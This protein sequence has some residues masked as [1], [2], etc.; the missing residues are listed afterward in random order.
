M[1]TTAHGLW[2]DDPP[3][4]VLTE[5]YWARLRELGF[6]VAALMLESVTPGFDPRY[7]V[8]DLQRL[9]ELARAHDV[10][11]VLTVWPEPRAEYL[12]QLR[13][14]LPALV[15]AAGAAALEFD[16]ESNWI[17]GKVVGFRK[18]SDAADALVVVVV[19]LRKELDVRSELTTFTMHGEN[20]RHATLAD[21]VDRVLGQ[22]YSV[23][24]RKDA[25]GRPFDVPWD[26]A[27]GPGRMQ[28]LTFDRS[29]QIPRKNGKPA[30]SCGLA[31]YDQEWPEHTGEEAMR[32][33]Y[34][35]ALR[36]QPKEVRWWSS[37][38]VIGAL[39]RPYA[40][41]FFRELRAA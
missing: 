9:G 20:G 18:L 8:A 7:S 28:R 29:L 2:I 41:R 22:G 10:E 12:L 14:R 37:K 6:T 40:V 17:G 4:V 26:H 1:G 3:R 24:H 35:E 19:E 39:S 11:L 38:W 25:E 15:R 33:A 31:A 13:Q 23:R 16:A 32:V 34:R 27:Y 30:I 21:D 5:A 36:Y